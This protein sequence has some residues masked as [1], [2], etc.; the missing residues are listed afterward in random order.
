MGVQPMVSEIERDVLVGHIADL[1]V[2]LGR[3][4][5]E[6]EQRIS[7]ITQQDREIESLKAELA[8]SEAAAKGFLG[9]YQHEVSRHRESVECAW[10]H[11]DRLKAELDDAKKMAELHLAETQ[12]E[13]ADR[14]F[15]EVRIQTLQ[16]E[17]FAEQKRNEEL[18]ERA[19]L[20]D[21]PVTISTLARHLG[22]SNREAR[23]LFHDGTFTCD[24]D[25]IDLDRCLRDYIESLRLEIY[26][27]EG[28]RAALRAEERK[29]ARLEEEIAFQKKRAD[30]AAERNEGQAY[31]IDDLSRLVGTL[32]GITAGSQTLEQ[33]TFGEIMALVEHGFI[34]PLDPARASESLREGD[35]D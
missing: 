10:S 29:T 35:S 21:R 6:A 9:D 17:L 18:R 4:A 26:G 32:R 34:D 28:D 27:L 12:R 14:I 11:A 15:G 31:M 22:I 8:K 19:E 1:E 3:Q 7:Q 13:R 25:A 23:S 33:T 24:R 5:W 16:N 30:D 2:R 20:E